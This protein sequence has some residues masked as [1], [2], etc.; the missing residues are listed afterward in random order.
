MS[1]AKLSSSTVWSPL[2]T[3]AVPVM[4]TFQTPDCVAA[5]APLTSRVPVTGNG[6]FTTATSSGA[7]RIGGGSDEGERYIAVKEEIRR[8]AGLRDRDHEQGRVVLKP[9]RG[10]EA[11]HRVEHRLVQCGRVEVAMFRQ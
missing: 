1:P 11:C 9:A 2:V 3:A 10:A 6:V 5:I 8:E 4:P 7:S